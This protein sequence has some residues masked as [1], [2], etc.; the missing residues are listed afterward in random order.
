MPGHDYHQPSPDDGHEALRA[1][2]AAGLDAALERV[3]RVEQAIADM[4]DGK[5]DRLEIRKAGDG[6][7]WAR[8]DSQGR[9]LAHGDTYSRRADAERG[10]QRANPGL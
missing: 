8:I 4:V 5:G 9:E 1:A 3:A 2:F 10:G 6:W 7:T